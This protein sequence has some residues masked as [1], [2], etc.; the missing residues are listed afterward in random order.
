MR[1]GNPCHASRGHS[2]S[3]T[4][5]MS[6]LKDSGLE[7]ADFGIESGGFEGPNQGVARMGGIDDGV[8]PKT[9]GSIARI[10]LLFE[11]GADGFDQFFF[12]F[13]VDFFTFAFE[14]RSEE[15]TSELQSPMYLVCRL[16][17]E[18]K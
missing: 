8:D 17:L 5:S 15:H 7:F 3:F 16:L 6:G 2:I 13:F 10:G 4:F 12:L 14:L 1:S 9:S 11:G 18:K